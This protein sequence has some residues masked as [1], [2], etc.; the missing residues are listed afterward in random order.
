MSLFVLP[1]AVV[2]Q[3]LGWSWPSAVVT[4]IVYP[5]L[6]Y[7]VLNSALTTTRQGGI[8]WRDTFYPLERL[9]SGAVR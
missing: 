2:A 7:A 6:F 3:R 1:A 8:R 4:P 9:R 5:V